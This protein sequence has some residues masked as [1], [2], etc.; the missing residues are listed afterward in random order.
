MDTVGFIRELP[1]DL[2]TA[3]QTT[4]QELEYADI[5]LHVVDAATQDLDGQIQAVENILRQ[6]K[7]EHIPRLMVLNKCD[8]LSIDHVE[9]L[10]HR[11]R[12]IGISATQG[13]TLGLVREALS[14]ML[15]RLEQEGKVRKM[16]HP[17]CLSQAANLPIVSAS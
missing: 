10:C 17:M 13:Q 3:F 8:T 6:L 14:Y 9:R 2:V 15:N 12:A 4:L 11:Y 16:F 5:L 7:F 1:E